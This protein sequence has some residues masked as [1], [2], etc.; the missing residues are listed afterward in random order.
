M[1]LSWVA[2]MITKVKKKDMKL[3]IES[4]YFKIVI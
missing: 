4:E 1:I 2:T 3:N